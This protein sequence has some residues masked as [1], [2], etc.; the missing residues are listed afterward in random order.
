MSS[1]LA[2]I[3]Q[4]DRRSQEPLHRQIYNAYRAAIV[5]HTLRPRERVPSTRTLADELG[6]S[7][8]PVLNAYGQLLAEGYFEAR[9]GSGTVVSS[10]LPEQVMRPQHSVPRPSSR[11]PRL[12]SVNYANLPSPHSV[13]RWL[14][15][16]RG[17]FSPGQ[18][19]LDHF[20]F[21][22]WSRLIAR[23]CRDLPLA[24]MHYGEPMG[25]RCLREVIASYLRTSRGVRAKLTIS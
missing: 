4:I 13:V 15:G 25:F 24:S 22:I 5:Q 21:K 17:A 10:T 16:R 18:A 6:V 9:V 23:R 20:P 3:I 11:V 19:A 12:R 7:R 2:P 14:A 8:I 1:G